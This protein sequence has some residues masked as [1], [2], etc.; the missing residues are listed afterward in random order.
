MQNFRFQ[1]LVL[2]VVFWMIIVFL[3]ELIFGKHE[4]SQIFLTNKQFMQ[5]QS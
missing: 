1:M 2:G 3:M 5:E 4:N